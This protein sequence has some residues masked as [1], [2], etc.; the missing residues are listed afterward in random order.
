MSWKRVGIAVKPGQAGIG[1]LLRRIAAVLGDHGLDFELEPAA[2]E[3]APELAG[4]DAPSRDTVLSRCDLVIALGGDGTVLGVARELGERAVP[5]LAVN[6]GHLGFLTQIHPDDVESELAAVLRGDCRIEERARLEVLS[7]SGGREPRRD[8]V[9]N[10]A[11][12]NKGTALAR[13]IELQVRVEE[14]LVA[15]YRS[16]GLIFATPTGS[17]AYNLSAGGPLLHPTLP[18]MVLNPICPHTLTQRPLVLPDAMQV[19]VRLLSTEAV[20]L[21]LDG[22]VGASLLPGDRVR[23]T[24]SAHPVRFVTSPAHNPFEILRTKLGWGAQ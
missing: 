15:T 3:Q 19:E 10:D 2:A 24:R 11:I 17:T 14:L 9:L 6:L 23:V 16:D 4:P 18:A 22:Q 5:I 8:L 13:M 20:T 21:T 7:A 1:A 12:L